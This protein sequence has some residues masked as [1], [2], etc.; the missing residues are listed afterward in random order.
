VSDPAG[1]I[2][3][4]GRGLRMESLGDA[5]PKA[6][7]PVGNEPVI[8]HHLRQLRDLGVRDV[9]VVVGYRADDVL[10]AVGDGR[11]V[12]LRIHY[13]LQEAPSGSAH[14]LG[15]LRGQL[16][17]SFLLLLGDYFLCAENATRLLRRLAT[18]E[19]AIA[20][21]RERDRRL[22]QEACELSVDEDGRV[23]TITEK[24]VAPSGNLKGCGFYAFPLNFLDAVAR[25]PRTALRDEYE[26]T[27]ALDLYVQQGSRLFAEDVL[28]WDFNLTRPRDLLDC[29]LRWLD[30]LG[31]TEF[32]APTATLRGRAEL[33]RAIIGDDARVQ[34]AVR[35]E[36]VV[37]F[38]GTDLRGRGILAR[39]LV[40]PR[41]V[42]PCT[43]TSL[44]AYY[45]EGR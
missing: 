40:T 18:G 4:A 29:N 43:S 38:P 20:A 34:G 5:F 10:R 17:S 12:G 26:L 39:A 7:L 44:S 1:V 22:I 15:R 35:L 32:V 27:T 3:A 41:G 30:R 16:R 24:P 9:H 45:P 37:V 19:A 8:N 13:V 23:L 21:K 36:D 33:C 42:I 11:E 31:V 28:T 14:A 2:L 25:T 6:L